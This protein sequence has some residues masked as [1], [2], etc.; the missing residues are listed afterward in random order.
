[1]KRIVAI[2]VAF[3]AMINVAFAAVNIN[4]ATK[5]ELATLN[6]IGSAKAQAII[7]YRTKNGPFKSF[8]DVDNVPGI[9][10]GTMAKIEKDVT[11]SG[12]TTVNAP[13]PAKADAK[14][15]APV[16]SS[17]GQAPVPAKGGAAPVPAPSNNAPVPAKA[18]AKSAP[19]VAAPA[20]TAD[21]KEMTAAEKKKAAAEE[22]KAKAEADKKAKAEKKAAADAEKKAKADKAKADKEAK[23]KADKDAKAAKSDKPKKDDA[24]KDDKKDAAKTDAPKK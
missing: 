21:K 7:D 19:A 13:V 11:L 23:A 14:V 18:D 10:A 17:T 8:A 16:P 9:G 22:K 20:K 2:L 1:M 15:A 12:K 4:T 24:K 3:I 6:G 5:E